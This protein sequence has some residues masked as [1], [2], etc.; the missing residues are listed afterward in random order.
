M[1]AHV[2]PTQFAVPL[3]RRQK[4]KADAV[5][6]TTTISDTERRKLFSRFF[7]LLDR[8]AATLIPST[9]DCDVYL[10]I[11]DRSLPFGK[12]SK[13]IP[14]R[15]FLNGVTG[16]GNS[17]GHRAG[18]NMKRAQLY[19]SRKALKDRGLIRDQKVGRCK[20]YAVALEPVW[21][22]LSTD[23]R[24]YFAPLLTLVDV[25]WQADEQVEKVHSVDVQQI[26][27]VDPHLEKHYPFRIEGEES[28]AR[29]LAPDAGPGS[30]SFSEQE[31]GAH[32]PVEPPV[33]AE[34]AVAVQSASPTP[35]PPAKKVAKRGRVAREHWGSTLSDRFDAARRDA[36]PEAELSAEPSIKLQA[37]WEHVATHWRRTDIGPG[38]WIEWCV[39]NWRTTYLTV[40]Q[41]VEHTQEKEAAWRAKAPAVRKPQWR[42]DVDFPEY[43]D[44]GFLYAYRKA[45]LD[46]YDRRDSQ[47]ARTD[48]LPGARLFRQLRRKGWTEEAAQQAVD[49]WL[50]ERKFVEDLEAREREHNARVRRFEAEKQTPEY[51][52]AAARIRSGKDPEAIP[53]KP[54]AL[55]KPPVKIKVTYEIED[56][57]PLPAFP[58]WRDDLDEGPEL[59]AGPSIGQPPLCHPV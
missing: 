30:C 48:L 32:A 18:L 17:R 6:A 43:P 54:V 38:D 56:M 16:K 21:A 14:D 19:K 57:P 2:D 45:F 58:V 26:H 52:L 11:A 3:D 10:F 34:P 20:R 39:K 1:N 27:S 35:A 44:F 47:M 7:E 37:Q 33:T 36:W 22:L 29:E 41:H 49:E 9:Y 4:R 12:L 28:S 46:E 13:D 50:A 25:E 23:E 55:A 59:S 8:R 5:T 15:W 42:T 24:E 51:R 40:F 31:E 53:V